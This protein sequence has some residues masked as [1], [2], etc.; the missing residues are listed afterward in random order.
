[1]GGDEPE[2]LREIVT[3]AQSGDLRAI[4]ELVESASPIVIG[5]IRRHV[6]QDA[7]PDVLAETMFAATSRVRSVREPEHFAH[8]LRAVA[9]RKCRDHWRTVYRIRRIEGSVEAETSVDDRERNDSLRE[10]HAALGQLSADARMI[11][12]L[13]YFD[14]LPLK[15]IAELL[16]VTAM[17]V[18]I[19]LYRARQKLK[20]LLEEGGTD[21][22]S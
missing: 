7:V 3:R 21:A 10:L 13:H 15:E 20:T 1:M 9:V 2:R 18:K 4:E 11:V 16:G 6:P 5:L 19:R 17:N 8:W 14:G 12:S 22:G